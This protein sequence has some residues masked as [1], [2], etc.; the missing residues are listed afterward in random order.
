MQNLDIFSK[1]TVCFE[2]L[3]RFIICL[4]FILLYCIYFSCR[5]IRVMYFINNSLPVLGYLLLVISNIADPGGLRPLGFW[6]L[7]FESARGMDVCLLCLYAV[8]CR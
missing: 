5:F 4:G 8:L 1:I 3:S 7:G 2:E 6:D